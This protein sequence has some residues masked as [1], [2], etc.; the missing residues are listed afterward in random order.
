MAHR[1]IGPKQPQPCLLSGCFRPAR[2]PNQHLSWNP[3]SFVQA[4]NHRDRQIA[5]AVQ[6]LGDACAR[7]DQRLQVFPGQALL[8]HSE[9]DG[10][11][12]IRRITCGDIE[13]L[14]VSGAPPL[15]LLHLV[16]PSIEG[17]LFVPNLGARARRSGPGQDVD[18]SSACGITAT[19]RRASSAPQW[20]PASG[21]SRPVAAVRPR[22]EIIPRRRPVQG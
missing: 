17:C 11:D 12:R 7:S 1:G 21:L 13:A 15:R 22:P 10:F 2:R 8:F 14:N 3:E 20:A 6:D 5:F 16:E 4:A 18:V 19:L 9:P